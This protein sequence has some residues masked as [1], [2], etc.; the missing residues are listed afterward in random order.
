MF[1]AGFVGTSNVIDAQLSQ[2]LLG[3][4]ATHSVR[5]ER[6]RLVT[7]QL[8]DGEVA[9][10]GVLTDVQYLGAE[11]RLRVQ[12]DNGSHL[13]ANVPSDGLVGDAMGGTVRL[14]WPRTAALPVAATTTAQGEDQE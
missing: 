1:V 3:V 4:Q 13:L 7:D 9:V 11:C 5:P 2:Q 14:A 10:D 12:L 8:R 6:I